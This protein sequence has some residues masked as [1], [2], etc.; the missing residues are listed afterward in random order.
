MSPNTNAKTEELFLLPLDGRTLLYAPLNATAL[1]LEGIV[2][3]AHWSAEALAALLAEAAPRRLQ[4]PSGPQPSP[5]FLGLV[6]T[7]ACNLRCRYCGFAGGLEQA[8]SLS[9][10][11]ALTAV[12]WYAGLCRREG[13]TQLH[14][15]LFGGEALLVP[16]LV[17]AV[18]RRVHEHCDRFGLQPWLRVLTNGVVDDAT[19][20]LL[21]R[22]FQDVVISLDGP[23][24]I[25]DHHRPRADGQGSTAEVLRTIERLAP[26]LEL[27]FR[28]CV[29]AA[30]APRLPEIATWLLEQTLPR[31]VDM[32]PLQ[33]NDDARRHGLS[34]P[35]GPAFV[36]G[37]LAA[38]RV[39]AAHGVEALHGTARL[40]DVVTSFCPAGRDGIIVGPGGV[41]AGC[42]LLPYEWRE[43]GLEL[44]YGRV[45]GGE[46]EVDPERLLSARAL[47]VRNKPR[48]RDCF[49]R[50]HCAGGCHVHHTWPGCPE[51]RDD[52]C[53]MTRVI[54]LDGL[55]AALGLEDERARLA[56]A[57]RDPACYRPRAGGGAP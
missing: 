32:E 29:T 17:E 56:R 27:G 20:A 21:A 12:D 53:F 31:V 40:D 39:L 47:D 57:P 36:R 11:D 48:C 50:W 18:A 54:A 49:V 52:L 38:A 14:V 3:P 55:L 2:G 30:T 23:P 7:R 37:Y 41:I 42:Y 22:W 19:R 10:E 5:P 6:P 46:V 13:R 1:L 34:P 43:R 35:S 24:D 25:Q 9:Q 33:D 15:E 45:R 16:A 4:A 44:E 26:T 8:A 51:E 28:V